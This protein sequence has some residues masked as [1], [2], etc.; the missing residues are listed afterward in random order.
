[1]SINRNE[2]KGLGKSF[3][4]LSLLVRNKFWVIN[5]NLLSSGWIITHK[6]LEEL[7][8]REVWI[9]GKHRDLMWNLKPKQQ[10]MSH[11]KHKNTLQISRSWL[12]LIHVGLTLALYAEILIF[13][14]C[15]MAISCL[16]PKTESPLVCCFH[17]VQKTETSLINI[18]CWCSVKISL[19]V[20][21]NYKKH[22]CVLEVF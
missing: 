8:S 6:V 1:M 18:M 2:R 4:F 20:E 21:L 7:W 11:I 17:F 14:K 9:I 16:L 22:S 13:L 12:W 3:Y 15:L 10:I 19:R 5:L